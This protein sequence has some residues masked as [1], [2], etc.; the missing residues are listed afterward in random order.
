MAG[1]TNN[2]SIGSCGEFF[3]AAELERRGFTVALP[4]GNTPTFDI[5]AIDRKT[6]RQI[7]IQVKTTS[8][9]RKCWKLGVKNERIQSKNIFYIFVCLNQMDT[10]AYHIVP[11][12]VVAEEISKRYREWL[13]S[14]N[15]KGE[16]HKENTI[17][18][19]HDKENRYLDQWNVLRIE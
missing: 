9:K 13:N 12:A 16:P 2:I 14:L 15:R 4:M 5:L 18:E 19:F 10:P 7:A 3:V 17:R 8:Y 11:S 6:N 1:K